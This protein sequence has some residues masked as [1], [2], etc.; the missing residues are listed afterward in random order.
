MMAL[1]IQ[2]STIYEKLKLF[3]FLTNEY[4]CPSNKRIDLFIK[5]FGA[6]IVNGHLS[7]H[8]TYLNKLNCED[9]WTSIKEDLKDRGLS[10]AAKKRGGWDFYKLLASV[11]QS[12]ERTENLEEYIKQYGVIIDTITVESFAYKQLNFSNN[13]LVKTDENKDDYIDIHLENSNTNGIVFARLYENNTVVIDKD[14][15]LCRPESSLLSN[16]VRLRGYFTDVISNNKLLDKIRCNNPNIAASL[17][18]GNDI[19][20]WSTWLDANNN[21]ISSYILNLHPEQ[22]KQHEDT[23]MTGDTFKAS[24]SA[25]RVALAYSIFNE[26]QD[27]YGLNLL[28]LNKP[29][30]ENKAVEVK[31]EEIKENL[32]ENGEEKESEQSEILYSTKIEKEDTEILNK[33]TVSEIFKESEDKPKPLEETNNSKSEEL[34]RYKLIDKTNI[35]KSLFL[36]GEAVAVIE[37][38][39]NIRLKDSDIIISMRDY[40]KFNNIQTDRIGFLWTNFN[41]IYEEY[42]GLN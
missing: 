37:D 29:T 42:K 23:K 7:S 28:D 21:Q 35:G 17:V 39:T 26:I 16:T 1:E 41:N 12:L 6:G 5:N 24:T 27:K 22:T 3:I 20:G 11:G 25:D 4:G 32:E 40:I 13:E 15:Q 36:D 2:A 33:P 38:E 30:E 18:L 19:D 8:L 34:Y 14:T 9:F 10:T 31:A